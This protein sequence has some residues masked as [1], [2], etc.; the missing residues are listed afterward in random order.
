MLFTAGQIH[1]DIFGSEAHLEAR[2]FPVAMADCQGSHP[3]SVACHATMTTE[4]LAKQYQDFSFSPK[5]LS[6]PRE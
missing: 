3:N 5:G 2:G 1:C 4:A 6:S